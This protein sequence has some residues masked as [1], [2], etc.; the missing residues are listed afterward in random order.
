[1]AI[2]I[3]G[4]CLNTLAAGK[5]TSLLLVTYW[6]KMAFTVKPL[7]MEVRGEKSQFLKGQGNLSAL[8]LSTTSQS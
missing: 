8:V 5:I 2:K 7:P 3:P 6:A 4:F 1:M